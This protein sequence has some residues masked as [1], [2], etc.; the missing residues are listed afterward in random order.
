MVK[1]QKTIEQIAGLAI[2]GGIVVGCGFVL[3]PFI[4]AILWAA[5][6]C[7][8]T[9]PLHELFLRWLHGRR[10][11]AAAMMTAVLSLVLIIP[12]V[13]AGLAFTDSVRSVMDWLGTKDEIAAEL[14]APVEPVRL[15]LLDPAGEA[16]VE[17]ADPNKPAA[18]QTL[19]SDRPTTT[20]LSHSGGQTILPPCPEWVDRI[21]LVGTRIS[22]N[23]EAMNEDAAL[24][25]ETW[26]PW[27]KSAGRW[28]LLHSLDFAHGLLQLAMSVLIAFFLYRDGEGLVVRLREGFQRISGDTAQHLVDVVKTTVQ[29]VVYGVIGTALAQGIVAGIGFVIA[30]APAPMILALLTFFLSFLPFG[31]PIVWIGAALWLFAM[32]QTGWG[33]FMTAY[34]LLVIS[35]VDNVIK[36]LIISRG[37]KLSFI[38]M[39]IGVLGGVAAFGFIGIFIGPTLLAVGFSLTQEMLEQRRNVSAPALAGTPE[40]SQTGTGS[41]P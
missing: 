40:D 41:Q 25:L 1:H 39:F 29:S 23:W 10:T 3:R 31:P 5:I 6:L 11:L 26:K 37:S 14:T 17:P 13:V 7:F 32:G 20:E 12:F 28:L 2:I 38:V 18:A 22:E 4:S 21:P 36:P 24:T 34:G 19:E 35:L 33:I 30:G 9:W 15:N 27:L 16:E 8:A